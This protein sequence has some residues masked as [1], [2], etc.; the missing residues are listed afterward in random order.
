MPFYTRCGFRVLPSGVSFAPS[1]ASAAKL[2]SAQIG[3]LLSVFGGGAAG[4]AARED[5]ASSDG[6]ANDTGDSSDVVVVSQ[7]KIN[8]PAPPPP[9]KR[10]EARAAQS[11]AR[12][13]CDSWMAKRI[14]A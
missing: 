9:P 14:E 2:D 13:E 3:A 11:E 8:A 1:T 12:N 7:T 10:K 5:V 6:G 4:S